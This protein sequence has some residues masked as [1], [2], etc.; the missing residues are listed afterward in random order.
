MATDITEATVLGKVPGFRFD[1]LPLKHYHHD[2]GLIIAISFP[3]RLSPDVA[4]A[5]FSIGRG[6]IIG[7]ATAGLAIGRLP[8]LVA[9]AGLSLERLAL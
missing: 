9:K 6:W 8:N 7:V 4:T 5:G 2:F 3:I 1:M